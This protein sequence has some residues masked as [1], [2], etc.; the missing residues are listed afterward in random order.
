MQLFHRKP[1]R[2]KNVSAIFLGGHTP[3]NCGFHSFSSYLNRSCG[4][5]QVQNC[6]RSRSDL[7]FFVD[8]FQMEFDSTNGDIERQGNLLVAFPLQEKINYFFLT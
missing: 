4:F 3:F 1:P 2:W 7:K 6:V 5:P 8:V